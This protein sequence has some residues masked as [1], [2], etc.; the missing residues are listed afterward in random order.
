MLWE[1]GRYLLATFVISDRYT[2]FG[3]VGAFLAVL[4][5]IFY[6]VNTILFGATLVCV[7]GRERANA[8]KGEES[9]PG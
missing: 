4:L 9:L 1:P 5:W 3:I 8:K 2:A 6:A 7:V